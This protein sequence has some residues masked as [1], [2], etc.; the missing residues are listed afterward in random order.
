M[1]TCA[2]FV[3]GCAGTPPRPAVVAQPERS[4]IEHLDGPLIVH[5]VGFDEPESVIYDPSCDC[6]LVSNV[7]GGAREAD[8]QSFISRV[9][10][11][12][13]VE[14]L[15][16]IDAS[17]PGVELHA[18]KGMAIAAGLL[19]VADLDQLRR[20]DLA[21]G[22]QLG[23]TRI[24][25]A[26]FLHDVTLASD[27]MLYVTDSGLGPGLS[28]AGGDAVY[29][30][31]QGGA[32]RLLSRSRELG[33]PS[34]IW[35]APGRLWV[36]GFGSGELFSLDLQNGFRVDV[37]RPP[38]GSLDGLALFRGRVFVS[39]WEGHVVYERT[40]QGFREHIALADAV[41]D[42]DV[43]PRRARLLMTHYR[44]NALSIHQL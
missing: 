15:K 36:V 6:Y 39:S 35:A 11:D 16:W 41:A 21:T 22:R 19:Y 2:L 29:A 8:D 34:G 37:A 30:V 13:R 14:A 44:D 27:G 31:T 10:P 33:E 25:G 9:R 3:L 17:R 42:L 28:P 7:V 1:A 43:D 12:G 18:P 5:D 20:F 23:S 32:I 4:E 24:P 26:T 40:E 38:K